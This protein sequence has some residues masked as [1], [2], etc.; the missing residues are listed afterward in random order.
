MLSD[1]FLQFKREILIGGI[2]LI[3]TIIVSG[4]FYTYN[5]YL[6]HLKEVEITIRGDERLKLQ[7]EIDAATDK[8]LND[9]KI[10]NDKLKKDLSSANSKI[11]ELSKNKI[12]KIQDSKTESEINES[13]K[14]M[15]ECLANHCS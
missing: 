7:S 6:E 15:I 13:Y 9:A 1:L 4:G 2:S 12:I 3:L 11:D 10:L 5:K 14:G 8:Q